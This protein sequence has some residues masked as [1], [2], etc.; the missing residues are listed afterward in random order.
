MSPPKRKAADTEIST[1]DTD[2]PREKRGAA[3]N[4]AEKITAHHAPT[5]TPAKKSPGAKTSKKT[6]TK[7]PAKT[8]SKTSTK[9]SPKTPAKTPAARGGRKRRQDEEE[10]SGDAGKEGEDGNADGTSEDK[11]EGEKPAAKRA[12][13]SKGKATPTESPA[14]G[15]GRGKG[16]SKDK[17]MEEKVEDG[18]TAMEVEQEDD[19]GAETAAGGKSPRRSPTPQNRKELENGTAESPKKSTGGHLEVP[20]TDGPGRSKSRSPSPTKKG[21]DGG[22]KNGSADTK[23][24]SPS[25]VKR[26]KS[27]EPASPSKRGK[28]A[29]SAS[30]TKKSGPADA[31]PEENAVL[32]TGHIYFF[33]RPKVQVT[34]VKSANDVARLYMILMP[35]SGSTRLMILTRKK[36]PEI[37]HRAR[38]WGFSRAVVN[39]PKDLKEYLQAETYETKT[40][41]ERTVGEARPCGEGVYFIVNHHGHT[42]LAYLLEIPEEP[43]PVQQEFNIEKNASF[44]ITVKNPETASP[45]WAGLSEKQKVEFPKDLQDLFRGRRF[46]PAN[47]V[48]L[49]D[50]EHAEFVIIGASD[51]VVGELGDVGKDLEDWE[52]DEALVVKELGDDKVFEELKLEHSKFK[53]EPLQGLFA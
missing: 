10:E 2:A 21:E 49:L 50:Y 48:R 3:R 12:K 27:T 30:P 13:T 44:I 51:D 17:S 16:Q 19:K 1:A 41:G 25:P 18:D 22:E 42:H 36:L 32:E 38:Y 45:P 4:A 53:S 24:R 8:P 43:G 46:I 47:P 31:K 20:K 52:K 37:G 26:G 5:R 29:E 9:A 33:Y 7:S 39:N 34:D 40:R 23:S 35:K 28:S 11:E 14:K 15:H 6:P